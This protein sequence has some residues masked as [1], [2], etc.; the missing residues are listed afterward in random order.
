MVTTLFHGPAFY[1]QMLELQLELMV[2]PT[3][4]VICNEPL[5]QMI[6]DNMNISGTVAGEEEHKISLYADDVLLCLSNPLSS[7]NAVKENIKQF[8][9]YSSYKV[10]VS[11]TEAMDINSLIPNQIKTDSE[12]IWLSERIKYLG[13]FI[14]P[15]LDKLSN[16]NYD[17]INIT[18]DD[19]T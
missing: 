14:S 19:L 7:I 4:F 16:T 3:H 13:I 17:K 18:E 6:R 5:A 1:I 10:N 8:D 11:K 12:F 2:T 15:Q 9:Y